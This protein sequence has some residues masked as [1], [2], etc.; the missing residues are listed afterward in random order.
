[1]IFSEN[2]IVVGNQEIWTKTVTKI[3]PVVKTFDQ[4][5][6]R[7]FSNNEQGFAY[8]PNDLSTMYQDAAGTVPVTGAGQAVGLIRDKSGRNNHAYQTTSAA[9][10]ILQQ[11]PILSSELVVNGD[12]SN[13]TTGWSVQNGTVA[14]VNGAAR[15]TATSAAQPQI[16]LPLGF[17]AG[18]AV[19]I[20]VNFMNRTGGTGVFIGVYS[21]ASGVISSITSLATNGVVKI[22]AI[23]PL[24]FNDGL[25]CRLNGPT[26]GSYVDFDNISIKEITGYRTDQN[27]LAFDGVDDKLITNLPAQLTGCTAIRSVPNVGTQILTGQT[28]PATYED[29]KDHCG[30]IVINRALT[31]SE[32]SAITA[33]FNKRA[34]V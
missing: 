6:R 8:D 15:V 19:E 22:K 1:M 18:K 29:N 2:T 24:G 31:P 23:I 14:V 32:T 17:L 12:F 26:S 4:V 34:G 30:L 7:L 10:P 33:E 5:M 27:Y 28:I 11:K 16:V 9:R 3:G 25:Y 20:S 21:I 13:G